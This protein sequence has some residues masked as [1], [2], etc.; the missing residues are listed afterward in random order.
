[1]NAGVSVALL[2]SPIAI[3]LIIAIL[4]QKEL[5]PAVAISLVMGFIVSHQYALPYTRKN[6]GKPGDS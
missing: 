1:V 4:F 5:I 3:A 6:S 2:R